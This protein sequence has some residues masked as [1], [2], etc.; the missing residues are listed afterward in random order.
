MFAVAGQ[1][2]AVR[3]PVTIGRNRLVRGWKAEAPRRL[4]RLCRSSRAV[5][6][7][8]EQD[9]GTVAPNRHTKPLLFGVF[10][11][12]IGQP[13]APEADRAERRAARSAQLA[14]QGIR[15]G[16]IEGASNTAV[17]P[18]GLRPPAESAT[19]LED[20]SATDARA[21]GKAADMPEADQKLEAETQI[22]VNCAYFHCGSLT[23]M[24]TITPFNCFT[25][26]WR[27]LICA[28]SFFCCCR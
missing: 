3:E 10:D 25:F 5:E 17:V 8:N 28:A 13:D 16:K 4:Q 7:H 19:I 27:Y 15:F 21:H 14:Q 12:I 18:H 2:E 20:P 22:V 11:A 23:C 1:L 26:S 9:T 6:E 24:S